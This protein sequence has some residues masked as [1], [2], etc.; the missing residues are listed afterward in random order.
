MKKYFKDL[1]V[2]GSLMRESTLGVLTHQLFE[3]VGLGLATYYATKS[4][5]A[6]GTVAAADL[7]FRYYQILQLPNELEEAVS[8]LREMSGLKETN[9]NLKEL[10]ARMR[11]E[12][13][14][15][16]SINIG[17]ASTVSDLSRYNETETTAED[18]TGTVN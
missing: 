7:A 16:D 6:A 13:E 11:K 10:S 1:F 17:L 5:V 9:T 14:R 15:L 3:T 8:C 18:K 12:S 4:Y 2:K